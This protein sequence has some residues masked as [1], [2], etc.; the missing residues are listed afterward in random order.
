MKGTKIL[1]AIGGKAIR[2]DTV[3]EIIGVGGLVALVTGYIG[4]GLLLF[5]LSAALYLLAK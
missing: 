2:A 5:G 1:R 4:S 3:P